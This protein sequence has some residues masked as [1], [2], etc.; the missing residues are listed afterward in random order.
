MIF[1]KAALRAGGKTGLHVSDIVGKK[2]AYC[3]A[4]IFATDLQLARSCRSKTPNRARARRANKTA[5]TKRP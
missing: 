4:A 2:H 5:L 1:E 3:R